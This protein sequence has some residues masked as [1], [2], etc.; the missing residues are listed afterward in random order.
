[1]NPDEWWHEI[2]TE[3][4]AEQIELIAETIEQETVDEL[5]GAWIDLD[6][7]FTAEQIQPI[8]NV[9]RT[10]VNSEWI[11]QKHEAHMFLTLL[12]EAIASEY[13]Q[14]RL[15]YDEKT[16]DEAQYWLKPE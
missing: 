13:L 3:Q 1:M 16:A 7:M 12:G 10:I 11:K 15:P 4:E 14:S 2:F 9:L 6:I 5:D 8:L